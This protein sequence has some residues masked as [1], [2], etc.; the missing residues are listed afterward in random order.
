DDP[1]LAALLHEAFADFP[2]ALEPLAADAVVAR[3]ADRLAARGDASAKPRPRP[4][5]GLPDRRSIAHRR[6]G[7]ARARQR[8]RPVHA[9]PPVPYRLR[10]LAAPLPGRPPPRARPSDDCRRHATVG[11]RR[12]D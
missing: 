1:V 3:L 4:S 6:I 10:D 12:G 7:G 8:T 11:G 5:S 9:G 2:S